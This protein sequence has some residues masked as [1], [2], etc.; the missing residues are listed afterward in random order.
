MPVAVEFLL[1][2]RE[3]PQH[4]ASDR[5]LDLLADRQLGVA[6]R[7]QLIAAGLSSAAIGRRVEGGSLRTVHRGVYAFRAG[8]LSRTAELM[9]A[10]LFLGDRAVVSHRAAMARHQLAEWSGFPE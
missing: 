6:S 2:Q 9:A 1:A 7:R 4:R 3:Q 10:V 8:P 5:L